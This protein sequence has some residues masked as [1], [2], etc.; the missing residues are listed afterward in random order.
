MPIV[1]SYNK[2]PINIIATDTCN[3]PTNN[4]YK[5][6]LLP[7]FIKSFKFTLRPIAASAITSNLLLNNLHKFETSGEIILAVNKAQAIK[8]PTTYHGTLIFWDLVSFISSFIISVFD[9]CFK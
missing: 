5:E 2:I 7:C 1:H 3:N 8:N 6:T 4:P 9:L